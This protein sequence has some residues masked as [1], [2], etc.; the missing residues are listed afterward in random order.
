MLATVELSTPTSAARWPAAL[1]NGGA[2]AGEG[3]L[4]PDP[5][6]P[7]QVYALGQHQRCL[8]HQPWRMRPPADPLETVIGG[9]DGIHL[10]VQCT[11]E[12]LVDVPINWCH[13]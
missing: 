12:D 11:P 13:A 7:G 9:L 10:R 3:G 5:D 4:K 2:Q 6:Q 1:G 8:P